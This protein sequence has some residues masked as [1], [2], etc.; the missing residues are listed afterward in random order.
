MSLGDP[1]DLPQLLQAKDYGALVAATHNWQQDATGNEAKFQ[2]L[3]LLGSGDHQ[4]SLAPFQ[5]ATQKLPQ[6][7]VVHFAF[8]R[9]LSMSGQLEQAKAAYESVLALN[10]NH[11]AA[12]QAIQQLCATLAIRDENDPTVAVT[13][14]YRA[15]ELKRDD[16]QLA[17]SVLDVYV[18]NGWDQGANDFVAML[19]PNLQNH[20]KIRQLR[21][22]LPKPQPQ[23]KT[24]L[25]PTY[26]NCPF[27]KQQVIFGATTCPHCKMQIRASA[28]SANSGGQDWQTVALTVLCILMILLNATNMIIVF[29]SGEA[30]SKGAVLGQSS[31]SLLSNV[32]ILFRVEFAMAIARV[33]YILN[34][35]L[36]GCCGAF[37]LSLVGFSRGDRL[38]VPIILLA[39]CA[40]NGF[41]AYLVAYEEQN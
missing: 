29:A 27:C 41:M 23:A 40:L 35:C 22:Q 12:P 11:P 26:E 28:F 14:L 16:P 8:A 39:G 4:A 20:P 30:S 3:G 31:L 32:L 7:Q 13:W 15:W 2:A 33:W 21:Q 38:L 17:A 5:L 19:D 10:P 25:D 24:P 34:A 36:T 37:S 6:D 18:K 9:A 1:V